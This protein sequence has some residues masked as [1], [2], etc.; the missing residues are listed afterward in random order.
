MPERL[1]AA[2][3]L[4]SG[5][6]DKMGS[7]VKASGPATNWSS[8]VLHKRD[9]YEIFGGTIQFWFRQFCTK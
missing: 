8:N 1:I 6:L 2:F 5:Q 3:T 4:G 7:T 9:K